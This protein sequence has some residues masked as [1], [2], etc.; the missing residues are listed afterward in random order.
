ME[1][2]NKNKKPEPTENVDSTKLV[3]QSASEANIFIM[4]SLINKKNF[5]FFLLYF[6][7][8]DSVREKVDSVQLNINS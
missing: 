8:K 3:K 5:A 4:S 6:P 1:K 7:P 2:D